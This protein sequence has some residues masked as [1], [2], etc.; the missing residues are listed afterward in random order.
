METF[1]KGFSFVGKCLLWGC[2]RLLTSVLMLSHWGE[3]NETNRL[4]TATTTATDIAKAKE[5]ILNTI[6]NSLWQGNQ[7]YIFC[8]YYSFYHTQKIGDKKKN[9]SKHRA[10]PRKCYL[11]VKKFTLK[12]RKTAANTGMFSYVYNLITCYHKSILALFLT[13][14]KG[15]KL[16]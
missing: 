3:N 15:S 6:G 4:E 1:H 14:G 16:S 10:F 11:R 7:S 8:F 12:R 13:W 9:K 2:C 5:P